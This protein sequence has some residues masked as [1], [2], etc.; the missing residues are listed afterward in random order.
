MPGFFDTQFA[1]DN[2]VTNLNTFDKNSPYSKTVSNLAPTIV[3]QI[4]N[5]NDPKEVASIILD[6]IENENFQA[7]VTAGEKAK[8]FLPMKK[9]L[10]DED[11]ERRVKEYY[12]IR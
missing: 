3:E 5:G 1:R 12:N 10:S 4:N 6:I 8:K 7:R 11:F 9:E 2:L